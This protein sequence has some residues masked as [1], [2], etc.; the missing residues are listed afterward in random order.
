MDDL[1]DFQSVFLYQKEW[2]YTDAMRN[3]SIGYNKKN[4]KQ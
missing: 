4:N 2:R 3:K 1:K